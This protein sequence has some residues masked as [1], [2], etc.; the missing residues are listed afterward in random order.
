MQSA[1]LAVRDYFMHLQ[2]RIVDALE[3]VD[4]TARFRREEVPGPDDT[5]S[6]PRVLEN[7]PR[8][9]KAAALVH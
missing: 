9:E 5:L 4:G 2:D 1:T 3:A 6:R 8:I 7:G